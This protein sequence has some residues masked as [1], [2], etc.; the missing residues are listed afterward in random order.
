MQYLYDAAGQRVKKLNRK[1]TGAN[2]DAVVYI[3][4]V[5]ELRTQKRGATTKQGLELHVLDGQKR[6][7][8]RRSGDS[9]DSKPDNLLVLGD[10]LGSANVELDWS[11]GSFVDREEFR[12]YG[13]TSFGSYVNKRYRFTGKERDEESGL[14]YHG[15]RYYAPGLARWMSPD[16]KGLVDGVNLY[17][18]VRSNPL[19]L[20]DPGGEES[21]P[22]DA[23]K[24]SQ[25]MSDMSVG[26]NLRSMLTDKLSV[27]PDNFM[28]PRAGHQV[29]S[30]E[31][32]RRLGILTQ[33]AQG[34][35]AYLVDSEQVSRVTAD[36]NYQGT[37]YQAG[38]AISALQYY[39]LFLEDVARHLQ[40][41][42]GVALLEKMTS[43]NHG[44]HTFLQLPELKGVLDLKQIHT[45]TVNAQFDLAENLLG[46]V[47]V[48]LCYA[49]GLTSTVKGPDWLKSRSDVTLLHESI[50]ALGYM[51]GTTPSHILKDNERVPGDR[52]KSK[53]YKRY[54]GRIPESECEATGLGPKYE[55]S[56]ISENS[57]RRSRK[58]LYGSR[59]GLNS[60]NMMIRP[61]YLHPNTAN[62]EFTRIT[63]WRKV[64][65]EIP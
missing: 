50:H 56:V 15:A 6:L 7:G 28:G 49:P 36:R 58:G 53:L 60:D 30:Q 29:S 4:G 62:F 19:N 22:M 21:L 51:N 12:P 46:P 41:F 32:E 26:A 59:F 39:D 35:S 44:K 52:I 23:A 10:H 64:A 24:A 27:V 31:F 55:R 61:Q 14:N 9:L 57:Y 43:N 63:N 47:N 5:L 37:P 54:A 16:P 34:K 11:L 3:D 8:R 38:K 20:V 2:W 45:I 25:N 1:Q 42:P 65:N 33:I 18:Y 48:I 17:G 40:T 13:E